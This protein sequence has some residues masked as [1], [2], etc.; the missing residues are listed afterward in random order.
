[1]NA[2]RMLAEPLRAPRRVRLAGHFGWPANGSA[3]I[4]LVVVALYVFM[5]VFGNMLAPFS[6][7]DFNMTAI[8]KPPCWGHPFGTD[9]FGRDVL[10]RVLTGARSILALATLATSLGVASGSA[11]GLVSGYRGGLVDEA[12]MR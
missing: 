2:Q 3:C 7:V 9:G 4:A 10:S 8:L 12:L 6:P 5:A 11:L 1:M